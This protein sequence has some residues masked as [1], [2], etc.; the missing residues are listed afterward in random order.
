MIDRQQRIGELKEILTLLSYL[1][2]FIEQ[3]D[4]QAVMEEIL[5][6]IGWDPRRLMIN[7][8]AGGVTTPMIGANNPQAT[9][10]QPGS[11]TQNSPMMRRNADEGSRLGG[12]SNNPTTRGGNT[13][14]DQQQAL[15]FA[16]QK[17]MAQQQTRGF[18]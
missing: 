17:M 8:G 15:M 9:L 12:N 18:F 3:L 16:L 5:M 7:Q 13:G 4:P 6:P 2:G 14:G 10:P 1:P 11:M